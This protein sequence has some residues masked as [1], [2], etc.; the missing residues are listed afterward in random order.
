MS[1]RAKALEFSAK[2]KKN[3]WERDKGKCIICKTTHAAPN[4]HFIRRSRGGLGVEQNGLTLCHSCHDRYDSGRQDESD[5]LFCFFS[6]YLQSK[7]PVWDK[8]NLIY[9][10][11]RL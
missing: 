4:A 10:K 6:A 9:D 11:W 2:T 5:E 3:I 8:N 7:Y 1:K